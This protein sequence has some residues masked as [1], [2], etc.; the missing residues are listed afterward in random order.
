MDY[1]HV[2][3]HVNHLDLIWIIL[4]II[5]FIYLKTL[6]SKLVYTEDARDFERPL[7]CY[8]NDIPSSF[9]LNLFLM[10][11]VLI[12]LYR[13]E[14]YHQCRSQVNWFL[15]ITFGFGFI[16]SLALLHIREVY[17]RTEHKTNDDEKTF[18]RDAEWIIEFVNIAN[19][20]FPL[21]LSSFIGYLA[22]KLNEKSKITRGKMV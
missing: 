14:R 11:V 17:A 20:M 21:V 15:G 16:Y 8:L 10:F 12:L 9:A 6:S 7:Q 2:L 22:S 19:S 5:P 4:L 3:G 13:H 18:L 1:K